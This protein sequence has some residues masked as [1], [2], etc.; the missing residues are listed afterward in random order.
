MKYY[1][2]KQRKEQAPLREKVLAASNKLKCFS[3]FSMKNSKYQL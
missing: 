2:D 3:W 1:V